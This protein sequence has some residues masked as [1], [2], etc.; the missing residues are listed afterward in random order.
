[1][2]SSMSPFSVSA[3]RHLFG[4]QI[5]SLVGTGLTTVALSLLAFDLAGEDAGLVLGSVLALKMVAYLLIAP[6][7]GG[8]AHRVPRRAWLVG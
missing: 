6:V 4:A 5:T 7:A 1:M 3:F 2:V 8:I